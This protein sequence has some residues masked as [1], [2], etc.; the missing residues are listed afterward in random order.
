MKRWKSFISLIIPVVLTGMMV[1]PAFAAEERT[2]IESVSLTFTAFE[3]S[4]EYGEVDV[5]TG[6]GPYSLEDV[7]FL[8]NTSSSKYPRVKVTLNAEDDYYFPSASKSL[9]ELNGEGASFSSASLRNSKSTIVVTVQ[10]KDY[11]GAQADV[12]DDVDWDYE[13]N[14]AWSEV[15]NAGYYEVRLRRGTTVVGEIMKVDDTQF[16]FCGMINQTGNWSFQVRTVNRYVSSNKSKWVSSERWNVDEE[17]LQ[18]LNAKAANGVNNSFYNTGATSVSNASPYGTAS[19][20]AQG[21]TGATTGWQ[22]N[23][24]GYWYRNYDGSW[25]ASCWQQINGFWYY[26]NADGYAIMNQWLHHTDGNWYYLGA[27]GAMLTNTRTPD[28]CYVDGNGVYIP[29]I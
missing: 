14:G 12:A 26:F 20:T 27:N 24:T 4:E 25:P 5:N 28:N 8:S 19:G 21:P 7:E 16:N 23:A 2:K 1:L 13:G 11:T 17:T 15:A 29:G 10:L 6:S 18:M 3:D 9:F 22:Q